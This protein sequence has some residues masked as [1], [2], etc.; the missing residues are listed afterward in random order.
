MGPDTLKVQMAKLE[1]FAYQLQCWFA[2]KDTRS[3]VT[4]VNVNQNVK[5]DVVSL[6]DI[7]KT[8]GPNQAIETCTFNP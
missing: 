8:P 3:S 1:Y 2:R 5:P 4:T 7:V 6:G